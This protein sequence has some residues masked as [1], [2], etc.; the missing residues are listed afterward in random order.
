MALT[1][2]AAAI[3]GIGQTEFSKNSG[4]SELQLASEAVRAALADAGLAAADVDGI[5]TMT[6]DA[7]D[8]LALMRSVG[9]RFV[10]WTSRTPFGGGGSSALVQHAAAAVASGAADV[11][12]IY[13][14]FN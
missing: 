11:V 6:N 5:V 10:R 3:A 2:A 9:M 8:E 4:R 12:V 14:A 1:R 7:N 13:R